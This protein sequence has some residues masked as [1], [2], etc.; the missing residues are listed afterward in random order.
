[1]FGEARDLPGAFKKGGAEM[2]K[3]DLKDGLKEAQREMKEQNK[4]KVNC[5]TKCTNITAE[6][7]KLFEAKQVGL[8]GQASMEAQM[9]EKGVMYAEVDARKN[10][11]TDAEMGL[12]CDEGDTLVEAQQV[13]QSQV[14]MSL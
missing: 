5:H 9:L 13:F 11:S 3:E 8:N 2:E 7:A 12:K 1:M 4:E 14:L 6:A 10:G